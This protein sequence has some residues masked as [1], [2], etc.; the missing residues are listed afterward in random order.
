MKLRYKFLIVG[1]GIAFIYT[2]LRMYDPSIAYTFFFPLFL[3]ELGL[4][5][6]TTKLLGKNPYIIIPIMYLI[7]ISAF[8]LMGF[9]IEKIKNKKTASKIIKVIIGILM[10]LLVGSALFTLYNF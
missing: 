6:V 3:A 9:A 7:S 8:Y 1:I 2:G 5:V 10:I 4:I